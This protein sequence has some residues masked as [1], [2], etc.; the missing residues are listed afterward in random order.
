MV[1]L[2]VGV[3]LTVGVG[4]YLYVCWSWM[5][6]RRWAGS[7]EEWNP[8]KKNPSMRLESCES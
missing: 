1:G 7:G 2:G 8:R 6:P 5:F 3:R 4:V